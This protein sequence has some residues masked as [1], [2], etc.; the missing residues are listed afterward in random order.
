MTGSI[1]I[2]IVT[3]NRPKDL[4]H[5]LQTLRTQV[6]AP[7]LLEEVLV[8]DNASTEPYDEVRTF[9]AQHPD[10]KINFI[11]SGENL[12][13]ARGRNKLMAMAKGDWLL[14]IDD[15]ILF[16]QPND[17]ERIASYPAKELFVKN[18][19]IAFAMRVLYYDT[20]EVQQT[21][22]PHKKYEKYKDK[23]QFLSAYYIGCA[24][25]M[26]RSV[27]DTTGL[28]P[29]DF[30]YG[31]EE[32]DLSYRILDAG[33]TIGY[34]DSV[35]FEH[36]E[37]PLGRQANHKK[38]SMQWINKSRVA[39]RYLPFIYFLSTSFL[40]SFQ[41]LKHAKGHLGT[42]LK[43]WVQVWKIPF[44]EKRSPI[45]KQTLDYLDQV[46]ARLWY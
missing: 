19:T 10:L 27:L 34:D 26:K 44:T 31:M 4:L 1:S 13:V 36:K 2:L 24:H 12:G 42:F 37:S 20:K 28:Y 23:H 40:W 45:K 15:D 21:A 22:F 5:L 9:I 16:T 18:N 39:Y 35:T 14:V 30:F 11:Y 46:E 29:P 7:A 32:Y 6:N 25:L 33:Y 43:S 38:L 41:Y 8:L 3:Y 17:L